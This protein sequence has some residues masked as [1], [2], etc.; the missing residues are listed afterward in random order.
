MAPG[1]FNLVPGPGSALGP[2]ITEHPDVNVVSFTGST[3]AGRQVGRSAGERLKRSCLELC[4]KIGQ[5]H[6]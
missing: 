3:T 4:R 2:A 1:V 5:H 6:P